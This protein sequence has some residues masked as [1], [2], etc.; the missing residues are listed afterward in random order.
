MSIARTPDAKGALRC[1]VSTQI[2]H[3]Q[4]SVVIVGRSIVEA[5]TKPRLPHDFSNSPPTGEAEF[6]P[7][8]TCESE[9]HR[10]TAK[11]GR[12]AFSARPIS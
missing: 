10:G 3:E 12:H 4:I 7:G 9:T 6:Y 11:A 5:Y 1:R 2:A 8:E